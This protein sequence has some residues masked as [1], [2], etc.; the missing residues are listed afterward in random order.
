MT[1]VHR[2]GDRYPGSARWL[3]D[4][5]REPVVPRTA[6]AADL[7]PRDA[8]RLELAGAFDTADVDHIRPAEVGQH[9]A[10]RALG[11]RVVSSNQHRRLA[12]AE[13][14]IHEIGVADRVECL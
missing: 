5:Q 13:A 14:R 3:A 1:R 4:E 11:V 10:D 2:P 7:D 8:D 6:C 12:L 9:V